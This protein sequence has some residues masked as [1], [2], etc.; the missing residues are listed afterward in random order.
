MYTTDIYRTLQDASGNW[1][2]Q[3]RR[4][5][6]ANIDTYLSKFLDTIAIEPVINEKKLQASYCIVYTAMYCTYEYEYELVS[7]IK[8][9]IYHHTIYNLLDFL[10]ISQNS[11][12][13]FKMSFKLSKS[14]SKLINVLQNLL[15]S[16]SYITIFFDIINYIFLKSC[17][18][19]LMIFF[20]FLN[21]FSKLS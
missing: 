13:Y 7:Y 15:K 14:S 11:L 17:T 21:I 10:K 9:Y 5:H 16:F 1:G 20:K 8:H 4:V 12:K 19:F 18:H 2:K 3:R 6:K